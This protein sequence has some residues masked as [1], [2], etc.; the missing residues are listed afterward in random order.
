MEKPSPIY[1][2]EAGG[3]TVVGCRFCSLNLCGVSLVLLR[4]WEGHLDLC[5][6]WTHQVCFCFVF[7]LCICISFWG[8]LVWCW[9]H[10]RG[11]EST[12]LPW[13]PV[14]LV[15]EGP[16]I[17]PGCGSGARQPHGT[18]EEGWTLF[19]PPWVPSL[20]LGV[21]AWALCRVGHPAK[22]LFP[23][24]SSLPAL[25]GGH[26]ALG[27]LVWGGAESMVE[28]TGILDSF[29]YEG[30]FARTNTCTL[31]QTHTN[32]PTPTNSTF[33]PFD[34]LVCLLVWLIGCVDLCILITWPIFP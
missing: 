15:C 8:D 29:K 14:L 6:T 19:C 5:P 20:F 34:C 4:G 23:P 17:W 16:G 26:S 30:L 12:G 24:A 33:R 2:G 18:C 7:S 3:S 31:K 27:L 13:I 25:Q 22:V 28:L 21:S 9:E 11:A 1:I 32:T 10:R